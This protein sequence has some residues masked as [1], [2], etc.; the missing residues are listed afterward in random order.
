MVKRAERTGGEEQTDSE[1]TAESSERQRSV[2]DT[3]WELNQHV[4]AADDMNASVIYAI[5]RPGRAS[6]NFFA[7]DK[8][9]RSTEQCDQSRSP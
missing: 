2:C 1:L 9:E 7:R 3:R 6:R 8:G 5:P 4:L